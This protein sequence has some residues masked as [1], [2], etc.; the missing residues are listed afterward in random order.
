MDMLVIFGVAGVREESVFALPPRSEA[1][2]DFAN[3]RSSIKEA[4]KINDYGILD[5]L[6]ALFQRMGGDYNDL[7]TFIVLKQALGNA[8]YPAHY[9]AILPARFAIII[10][11]LKAASLTQQQS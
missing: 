5:H 10:K 3:R 9:V 8:R 4:G 11:G 7:G 1:L 6:R 2:R